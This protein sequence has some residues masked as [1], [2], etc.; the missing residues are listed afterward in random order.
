MIAGI[1]C[2]VCGLTNLADAEAAEVFGADDLGF[3]FAPDSP[4][5]ITLGQYAAMA[6]RLPD[7]RK[8]AVSVEPAPAELEALRAAGFDLFQI[9]FRH[10]RPLAEVAAWSETVGVER[11]L[12]APKLPPEAEVAAAWLPLTT[13]FMLDTFHAGFG[14]SGRTGDWAKFARH[15]RAHPGHAWIVAGGLRAE[16]I[17]EAVRA[18]GAGWIDLNSGVERAP[19]LKD[20][21]RLAA[22]AA[23]LSALAPGA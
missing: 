8:V 15:R 13:A 4:R 5:R 7:R 18:S 22:V 3:I 2:K 14:G 9:H 17:A 21:A 20:P 19:G 12:L 10:D 11:L 1:R 16:N 6:A 23:A